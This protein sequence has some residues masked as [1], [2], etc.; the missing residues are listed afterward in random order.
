MKSWLISGDAIMK[1]NCVS[2]TFAYIPA[3]KSCSCLPA[4]NRDHVCTSPSSRYE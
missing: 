3:L 1:V 2:R 4:N